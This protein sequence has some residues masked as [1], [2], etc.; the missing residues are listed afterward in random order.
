[1][2]Q[3][4]REALEEWLENCKIEINYWLSVVDNIAQHYVKDV[5]RLLRINGYGSMEEYIGR[6]ATMRELITKINE[7]EEDNGN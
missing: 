1:M 6:V 5:D 3:V 2:E 7:A 4:S